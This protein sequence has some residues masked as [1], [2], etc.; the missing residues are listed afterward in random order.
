MP[1]WGNGTPEGER[2]SW[3]LVRFIRRLPALTDGEVTDIESLMPVN[4]EEWQRR[5]EERR[6]LEGEPPPRTPPAPKHVHPA[7]P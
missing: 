1:A 3:H 4:R 7:K 6:F 2:S 5:E